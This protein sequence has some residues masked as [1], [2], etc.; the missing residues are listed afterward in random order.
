[1]PS[2]DIEYDP[3]V[4]IRKVMNYGRDV[5]YWWLNSIEVAMY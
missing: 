4:T 1:M 3:E 5:Q 2:F